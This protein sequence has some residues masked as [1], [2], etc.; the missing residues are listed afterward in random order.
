MTLIEHISNSRADRMRVLGKISGGF[1]GLYIAGDLGLLLG[2]FFGH[3]IDMLRRRMLSGGRFNGF[4]RFGAKKTAK[5]KHKSELFYT[6]FAVMGHVVKAKGRVTE[7]EIRVANE[8]MTRIG[9]QGE[10]LHQA[11]NAFRAGKGDDFSLDDT[12]AQVRINCT[13]SPDLLQ[14]F[15]ELQIQAAFA[16]GYLHPKAKQLLYII[17]GRLGFSLIQLEQR[18]HMQAEASSF[19]Q[20]DYNQQS[21]QQSYYR[22]IPLSNQI[23]YAYKVL[24]VAET[25]TAQDVKRAYRKLMNEYHPDKLAAK[26]LPAGMMEMAKQRAQELQAAY[27]L[28]RKEQGFK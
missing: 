17:A 2:L 24:G 8:I 14:F 27:A 26:G 22:Q 21:Q 16:D 7:D 28:I 19:Q 18:L 1:I 25:T 23:T 11:Q 15:L 5:E 3:G 10:A 6:A 13:E 4:S 9:L 20:D 12:L